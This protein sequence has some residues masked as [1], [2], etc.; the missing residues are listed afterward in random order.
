[1]GS[2]HLFCFLGVEV[3]LFHHSRRLFVFHM[4]MF[5]I[6]QVDWCLVDKRLF[7]VERNRHCTQKSLRWCTVI[8]S[9]QVHTLPTAQVPSA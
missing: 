6:A 1:M 2:H 7:S 3:S 5:A 8:N 4:Q 9:V